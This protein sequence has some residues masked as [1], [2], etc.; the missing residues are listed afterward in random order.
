MKN[1]SKILT[2]F[3]ISAVN[4]LAMEKN[5]NIGTQVLEDFSKFESQ[6]VQQVLPLILAEMQNNP[7]QEINDPKLQKFIG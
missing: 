3:W 2:A 6:Q 4:L 5:T 1:S 7:S